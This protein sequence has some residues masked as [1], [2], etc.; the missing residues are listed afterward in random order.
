MAWYLVKQGTS[1]WHES[2]G[3]RLFYIL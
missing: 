2:K 1:S 3:Q